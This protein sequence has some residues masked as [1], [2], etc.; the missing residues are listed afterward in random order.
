MGVEAGEELDRILFRKEY[1]RKLNGGIFTWG[2]GSALGEKVKLLVD[3]E[4]KPMVFFSEM[5][6]RPKP[7]DVKPKEVVLWTSYINSDGDVEPLPQYSFLTSRVN[8]KRKHY[9]L[10]CEKQDEIEAETIEP[11]NF[12][13]VK[14]L[15]SENNKLGYSQVTAVV[16]RRSAS[17][18]ADKLYDV[19]FW[20]GLS[21][22]YYVVL[23]N[24]APL[25]P[26]VLK[27][28]KSMWSRSSVDIEEWKH[29]VIRIREWADKQ[30]TSRQ[31]VLR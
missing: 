24:P 28:Y 4:A 16:E 7:Q 12:N 31:I 26:S 6:S 21:N 2:I 13:H 5:K 30:A 3:K 18:E 14:N 29:W 8:G 22:P 10:I 23:A 15:G 25:K 19:M 9:A 17:Q 27:E 11:L 20:A 1:E